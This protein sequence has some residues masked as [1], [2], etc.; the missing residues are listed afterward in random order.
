MNE[1]A[2]CPVRTWALGLRVGRGNFGRRRCTGQGICSRRI[3]SS[4]ARKIPPCGPFQVVDDAVKYVSTCHICVQEMRRVVEMS[5]QKLCRSAAAIAIVTLPISACTSYTMQAGDYNQLKL[6][7]DESKT[8]QQAQPGYVSAYSK[9]FVRH[10]VA[11][12]RAHVV[13]DTRLVIPLAHDE[14]HRIRFNRRSGKAS[15]PPAPRIR[16]ARGESP[17]KAMRCCGPRR[18]WPPASSTAA[19]FP[20]HDAASAPRRCVPAHRSARPA[21]RHR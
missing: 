13:Q 14:G 21:D 17:A 3:F 6:S 1:S 4:A 10:Q 16:P 19:G 15:S 7:N 2:K 9:L 12:R 5:R 18:P 20:V 11:L 8:E